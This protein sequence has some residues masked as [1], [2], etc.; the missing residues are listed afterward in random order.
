MYISVI[1]R[2]RNTVQSFRDQDE[3]EL[4]TEEMAKHGENFVAIL[5]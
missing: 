2:Y 4:A 3:F 5:G 1:A